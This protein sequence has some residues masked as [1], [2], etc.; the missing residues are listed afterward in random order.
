[1]AAADIGDAGAALELGLDAIERG[2]P[3]ADQ[4]RGI[5][6]KAPAMK[7]GPPSS[8]KTIACSGESA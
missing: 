6:A 8:A 3:S 2:Q 1:M 4:V 5:T 7:A